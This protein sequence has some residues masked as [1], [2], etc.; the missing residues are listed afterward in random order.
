VVK[1][2]NKKYTHSHFSQANNSS[3][4][5]ADSLALAHRGLFAASPEADELG[6]FCGTAS[7]AVQYTLKDGPQVRGVSAANSPRPVQA[8]SIQP[9]TAAPMEL[10]LDR[11]I[12]PK[13]VAKWR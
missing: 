9:P 13:A 8:S 1:S 10:E 12:T 2:A 7:I 3:L 6:T 4:S 11:L 5:A